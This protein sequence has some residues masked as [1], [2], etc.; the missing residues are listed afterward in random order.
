MTMLGVD[1]AL[2]VR[3]EGN[4]L[5]ITMPELAPDAAPCRHAFALKIEGGEALPEL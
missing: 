4:T 5:K 1:G 2:K 3:A